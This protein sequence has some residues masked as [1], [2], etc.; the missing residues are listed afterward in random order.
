MELC[1]PMHHDLYPQFIHNEDALILTF[2]FL[3]Y[4]ILEHSFL[5]YRL[6]KDFSF[7]STSPSVASGSE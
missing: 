2:L 4:T 6:N 5:E 3:Y 7:A 1:N